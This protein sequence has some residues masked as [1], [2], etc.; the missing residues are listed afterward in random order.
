MDF[1]SLGK[2]KKKKLTLHL[3]GHTKIVVNHLQ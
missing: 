2:K 3:L 1:T